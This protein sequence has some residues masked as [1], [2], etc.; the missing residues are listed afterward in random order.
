MGQGTGDKTAVN[1]EWRVLEGSAPA[2]PKK[3]RRIKV[4]K[5]GLLPDRKVSARQEPCPPEFFAKLIRRSKNLSNPHV[6]CHEHFLK[7]C[8][9]GK[10]AL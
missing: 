4:W 5:V 9:G 8:G 2:L 3:F 1:G 6:P 7:G 10:C